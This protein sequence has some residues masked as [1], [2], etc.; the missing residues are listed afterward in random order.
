MN[1]RQRVGKAL[2]GT[3]ATSTRWLL[4]TRKSCA[5]SGLERVSSR[6]QRQKFLATVDAQGR[7]AS[8]TGPFNLET[9]LCTSAKC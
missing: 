1:M 7:S 4:G 2:K 3:L 5:A 6:S 9:I 8:R